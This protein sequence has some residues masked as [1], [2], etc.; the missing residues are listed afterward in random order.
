M[1]KRL[2]RW[3]ITGGCGFIGTSLIRFLVSNGLADSIRVIDNLSTG[4]RDSL[5]LVTDYSEISL[6]DIEPLTHTSKGVVELVTADICNKDAAKQA[7]KGADVIIHLAANTGV[8]PSICDPEMDLQVNVTGLFNYLEA[9]REHKVSGFVFASSGA[10]IGSAVPPIHEELACHPI[11]PY[12]ASKLAGE[13][14]CSAYHGS[15]GLETVSLRFSNVYGP[16][17]SHKGSLVAKLIR[18]VVRKED[19]VVYGDGLQTRDFIYIDDLVDAVYAAACM[20]RGGDLYQI[21]TQQET[22]VLSLVTLLAE[23]IKEETGISVN[24][25]Y[26]D[27]LTGDV[28]R[29]YSDISKAVECLRWQPKVQLREGLVK[30]VRWFFR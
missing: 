21:A 10:P 20:G 23:I 7:V 30:T 11:S 1:V 18:Q 17:S 29:N 5:S 6:T 27:P 13:G 4:S 3:L 8:Q 26:G 15:Y 28:R 14:Y 22:S 24:I 19:W 9:A 16:L 12:G 25:C 2:R